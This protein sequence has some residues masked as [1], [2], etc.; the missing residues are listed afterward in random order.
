MILIDNS[1][2]VL[3]I[4]LMLCFNFKMVSSGKPEMPRP[5]INA[6]L[7]PYVDRFHL[8]LQARC[9]AKT[10]LPAI[11]MDISDTSDDD[12]FNPDIVG[13]CIMYSKPLKIQIDREY[14]DSSTDLEREQLIFHELGHCV[15]ER[16]HTKHK[17]EHKKPMSI[18]YPY[19]L[20]ESTYV[21]KYREYMDELFSD[22]DCLSFEGGG[23]YENKSVR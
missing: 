19:T 3:L 12:P 22:V 4:T 5:G 10:K 14:F 1:L 18:M 20:S 2:T 9:G 7:Q 8:Q 23:D 11:D 16:D 17:D 6:E 21:S 15:L 13:W